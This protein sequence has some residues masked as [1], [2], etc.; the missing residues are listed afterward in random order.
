MGTSAHSVKIF[1]HLMRLFLIAAV[2]VALILYGHGLQAPFYLDDTGVLETARGGVAFSATRPLGFISFY[3]TALLADAFGLLFHWV[4]SFYHRLANLCVHILASTVLFGLTR[5]LTR[6]VSAGYA[7]GFLFLVHPIVSQPIMYVSQRFESLAVL[8]MFSSAGAY[9]RFRRTGGWGWIAGAAVCGLAAALTK[10]T[11]VILP[12]WI[13]LMECTYFRR[14]GWDRRFLYLIPIGAVLAWP[15]WTAFRGSAATL[16]SIPVVPYWL[17]QGLVLLKHLQLVIYPR[18]QF[19]LYD[20]PLASGLSWPVVGAWSV[21]LSLIATGFLLRNRYPTIGFGILTFFVLLLPV[22]LL[23]LPDI[24][25][26]HRVYGAF[27]GIAMAMGSLLAMRP[28]PMIALMSVV[29]IG[30]L[31]V[32]TFERSGEWN[33]EIPFFEAHRE[34]FPNHPHA[35]SFLAVHYGAGGQ[36]R[37]AIE[38]LEQGRRNVERFNAYYSEPGRLTVA[39]NLASA[40]MA[41][42]ELEAAREVLDQ[43]RDIGS[44]EPAFHQAEGNW[45]LASDQPER[46]IE[47]FESVNALD[48]GASAAWVGLETAHS[49]L[50]EQDEAALAADRLQEIDSALDARNRERLSIP[51]LYRSQV[52]FAILLMGFAVIF[53]SLRFVWSIARQGWSDV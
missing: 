36:V 49:R 19:L 40:R 26:E 13:L 42:G 21:V 29:L 5:E 39:L 37:R 14:W 7:A 8:F 3:L 12:V 38:V 46:A 33:S 10:E 20:F 2:P 32:R 1:S 41:M 28:R 48:P 22:T 30:A 16:T 24:F 31:G 25:F 4:P 52:T 18:E 34:R 35:L 53:I 45:F 17:T 27:G 43:V 6:N 9:A 44:N 23:P 50:G 47:A 51:A 15:A 11:A